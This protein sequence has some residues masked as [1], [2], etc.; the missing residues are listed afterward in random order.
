MCEHSMDEPEPDTSSGYPSPIS[1]V[2]G[3][4]DQVRKGGKP[5]T[6]IFIHAG[7]GFHSL[8]NEKIHLEACTE[9]VVQ[10]CWIRD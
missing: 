4:A 8:Q 3:P 2:D 6:A 9:Y 1:S 10:E 7:A 5:V